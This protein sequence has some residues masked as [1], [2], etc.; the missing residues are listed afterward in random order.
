VEKIT[1]KDITEYLN[2]KVIYR[3]YHRISNKSY[4]GKCS[5][6]L[7]RII[8]HLKH[9]HL[10]KC[11]YRARLLYRAIKKYGKDMFSWE[12]I[13]ICNNNDVLDEREKY[14]INSLKTT[15][16]TKGYNITDGG[17][18]GNTWKNL[19]EEDLKIA[20]KRLSESGKLSYL[21]NPERKL[22]LSL[23]LKK[24]RNC[25]EKSLKNRQI[26]SERL[27]LLNKTDNRFNKPRSIC[28]KHIETNLI[29][30]SLKE[31][32]KHFGIHY[33]TVS[34]S[35]LKKKSSRKGTFVLLK[36]ID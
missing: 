15:D 23:C 7:N 31:A 20:K 34:T 6:G 35:I 33:A 27:K 4:I 22:K 18:G 17:T 13:E 14:Y 36:D 2:K 26:S 32:A 24:I 25:P 19:S 11:E 12:I 28:V 30:S 16:P 3:I 21:K 29:F 5:N 10:D 9:Y 8:D 1:E